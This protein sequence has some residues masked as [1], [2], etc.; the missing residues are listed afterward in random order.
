MRLNTK[1]E[2]VGKYHVIFHMVK[3]LL[4]YKNT[5]V[6]PI[7]KTS[8]RKFSCKDFSTIKSYSRCI[9]DSPLFNFGK[10]AQVYTQS[11]TAGFLTIST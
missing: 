10:T 1:S 7:V 5:I 3:F 6:I 9:P 4:T 8:Q 2:E 11:M